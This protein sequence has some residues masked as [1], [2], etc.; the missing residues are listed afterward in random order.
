MNKHDKKNLHT[1]PVHTTHTH[2]RIQTY[3]AHGHSLGKPEQLHVIAGFFAS[4]FS[5]HLDGNRML[6]AAAAA[7]VVLCALRDL[8]FFFLKNCYFINLKSKYISI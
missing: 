2:I 8:I 3:Q 1:R 7:A 6:A 4:D 5:L